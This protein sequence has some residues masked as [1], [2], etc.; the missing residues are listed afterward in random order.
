MP[1]TPTAQTPPAGPQLETLVPQVEIPP[2]YLK[3]NH[4]LHAKNQ[5]PRATCHGDLSQVD[6]ATRA[7][8]PKMAQCLACHDQGLHLSLIHI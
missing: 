7:Q 3:F 2:P 4:Q 5:V 8:L 1:K 6:L